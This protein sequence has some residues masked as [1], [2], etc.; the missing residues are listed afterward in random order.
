MYIT[1]HIT[2]AK[3]YSTK[4]GETISKI[5]ENV[6]GLGLALVRF[7]GGQSGRNESPFNALVQLRRNRERN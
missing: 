1:V 6:K 4:S 2:T 3:I 5:L 7:D